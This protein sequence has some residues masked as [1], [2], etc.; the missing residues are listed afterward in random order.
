MQ[1]NDEEK[2]ELLRH[3]LVRHLYLCLTPDIS[4]VL[5]KVQNCLKNNTGLESVSADCDH[6]EF[7][8]WFEAFRDLFA[9]YPRQEPRFVFQHRI[10]STTSSTSTRAPSRS[11]FAIAHHLLNKPTIQSQVSRSPR[12][13]P[14]D[15][16]PRDSYRSLRVSSSGHHRPLHDPVR[17]ACHFPL[18][19]TFQG[20]CGYQEPSILSTKPIA[21]ERAKKNESSDIAEL[22]WMLSIISRTHTNATGVELAIGDTIRQEALE[23]PDDNNPDGTETILLRPP[24][25]LSVLTFYDC[26]TRQRILVTDSSVHRRLDIERLQGRWLPGVHRYPSGR[27]G[28]QM[29]FVQR[30]ICGPASFNG[31]LYTAVTASVLRCMGSP[32]LQESRVSAPR[33]LSQEDRRDGRSHRE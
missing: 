10:P 2:T 28:H 5:V 12:K 4:T 6:Q 17:N 22:D 26:D 23:D 31:R 32:R 7:F 11:S 25:R 15:Q 29:C 1:V 24:Q 18:S 21:A 14:G 33:R 16:Q 8:K 3:P 20:S 30:C 27:I 19:T 9:K 13:V